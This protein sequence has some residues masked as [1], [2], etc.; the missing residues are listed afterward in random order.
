MFGS[1]SSNCTTRSARS[2]S[3]SPRPGSRGDNCTI[4]F[5]FTPHPR[6]CT[7]PTAIHDGDLRQRSTA[8]LEHPHRHGRRHRWPGSRSAQR[9]SDL[10]DQ[11]AL[12]SRP[13]TARESHAAAIARLGQPQ[14]AGSAVPKFDLVSPTNAP[15]IELIDKSHRMVR[16]SENA[17][18]AVTGD[19]PGGRP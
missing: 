1:Q 15:Y 16:K 10:L 18:T 8:H 7:R 13:G 12:R 3:I 2:K 11:D 9:H 17:T 14:R 6:K 4:H 5:G 19:R